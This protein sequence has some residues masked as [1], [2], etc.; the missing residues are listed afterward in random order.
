MIA[1]NLPLSR[2]CRRTCTASRPCICQHLSQDASSIIA[3]VFNQRFDLKPEDIEAQR[4]GVRSY[5]QTTDLRVREIFRMIA[6][7]REQTE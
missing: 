6:E 1:E 5:A 7:S 2:S 4:V 3:R